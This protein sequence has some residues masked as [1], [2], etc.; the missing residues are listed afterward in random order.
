MKKVYVITHTLNES[1]N[2]NFFK[3]VMCLFGS[4]DDANKFLDGIKS[5]VGEEYQL[6][7]D[8]SCLE[9]LKRRVIYTFKSNVD[10]KTMFSGWYIKEFDIQ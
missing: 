6:V 8:M 2:A 4:L 5:K 1:G 7:E 9:C 10:G 3:E